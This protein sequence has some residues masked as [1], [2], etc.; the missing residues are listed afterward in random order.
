ML[1]DSPLVLALGSELH[2]LPGG[3]WSTTT[4]RLEAPTEAW[5]FSPQREFQNCIRLNYGLPWSPQIESAIATVGDIVGS[6]A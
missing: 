2:V 4:K 5:I 1:H 3:V 6:L